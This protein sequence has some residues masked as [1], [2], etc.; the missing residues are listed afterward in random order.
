MI[1]NTPQLAIIGVGNPDR[2]DDAIGLLVARCLKEEVG[3]TVPIYEQNGE[4]TA[5]MDTWQGAD[6]VILIDAMRSGV[7]P[8]TRRRF[9]VSREPLPA[10]FTQ[11]STHTFSVSEA[12]ELSRALH[13]LPARM[14]VYGIEGKTFTLGAALSPEVEQTLPEILSQIQND[15]TSLENRKHGEVYA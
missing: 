12:I 3:D 5:L 8:G 15:I 1:K 7:E 2:G 9:E 10:V 14:I 13:T 6:G 4:A 11:S